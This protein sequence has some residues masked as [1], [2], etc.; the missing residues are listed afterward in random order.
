MVFRQDIPMGAKATEE[1]TEITAQEGGVPGTKWLILESVSKIITC[2]MQP[3]EPKK[4]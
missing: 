1:L 4:L 2:F 3:S